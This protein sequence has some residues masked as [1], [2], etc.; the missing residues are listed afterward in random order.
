VRAAVPQ[1]PPLLVKVAPD[2]SEA[3]LAAVVE[4]CLAGGAQGLIVSNTTISRPAGLRSGQARQAGGLSGAPLFALSTRML[5]LAARHA[6]GRLALVGAGGVS[7]GTEALAKLRAGA[8]LVQLYTGFA[9]EGPA[10]VARL[11]RELL[12]ALDAGGFADATAAIGVDVA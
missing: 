12:A 3:G 10:I 8:S 1:R 6:R 9:Y 2:L 7:S 11:K 4:T 5:A